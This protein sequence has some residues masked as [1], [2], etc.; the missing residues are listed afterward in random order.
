MAIGQVLVAG[1][2]ATGNQF[3]CEANKVKVETLKCCFLVERG[4]LSDPWDKRDPQATN[5]EPKS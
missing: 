2:D 5:P 4:P 1:E 3:N